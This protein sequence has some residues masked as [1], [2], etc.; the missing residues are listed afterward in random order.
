MNTPKKDDGFDFLEDLSKEII[1]LPRKRKKTPLEKEEA[2]IWINNV[3]KALKEVTP[4]QVK[5]W[6]EEMFPG[7]EAKKLTVR[8]A[9]DKQKVFDFVLYL[10]RKFV[11]SIPAAQ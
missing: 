8:T 10:H 7:I 11:L 1:T 4:E 5:Q 6:A 2:V 3:P 9:L